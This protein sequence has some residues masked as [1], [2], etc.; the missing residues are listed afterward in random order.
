MSV[1]FVVSSMPPEAVLHSERSMSDPFH[2]GLDEFCE[3]IRIYARHGIAQYKELSGEVRRRIKRK[4]GMLLEDDIT[5]LEVKLAKIKRGSK[6]DVFFVP[7][8][9]AAHNDFQIA[10]FLPSIEILGDGSYQCKFTIAFWIDKCG[11]KLMALRLEPPDAE[12]HA[13]SYCHLQITKTM[14]IKNG[15]NE[16][17]LETDQESWVPVS[18]PGFA[19]EYGHPLHYFAGVAIA[20][21]GYARKKT[22]ME[23]VR[24]IVHDCFTQPQLANRARRIMDEIDRKFG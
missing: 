22:Q 6:A 21:H 7:A 14:K 1:E 12:T 2:P 16:L 19:V 17:P 5:K 20:I 9:L 23:F 15:E 13:H 10:L 8:P 24:K 11:G 18:Y 3:I 4:F